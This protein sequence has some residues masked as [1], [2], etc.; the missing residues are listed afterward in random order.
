MSATG[1]PCLRSGRSGPGPA[2]RRRRPRL[3]IMESR[4]LLATFTVWSTD[5]NCGIDPSPGDNTGTLRQAIVDAN[6]TTVADAIVFAIDSG[7]QTIS[8]QA[9]LPAISEPV[10]IDGTTQPGWM[11]GSIVELDGSSAGPG[12]NGLILRGSDS[13]IRGLVINRF[14]GCGIFV[15]GTAAARNLIVGNSIGTDPTGM[16]ARPNGLDGIFLLDSTGNTIGGAACADRNVISGNGRYG[17][18]IAGD[19]SQN[20]VA[21]NYVGMTADGAGPLGN[22][23]FGVRLVG[24]SSPGG[25]HNTIGGT[26]A[27]MRNVISGGIEIRGTDDLIAGNFLGTDATGMHALCCGGIVFDDFGIKRN[28]T[29]GG[30]TEAARNIISGGILFSS[31]AEDSVVQG[32]FIGIDVTG[33][34]AFPNG[35]DAI[36]LRLG[37]NHITIGGNV[38][39]AGNV[40]SGHT[41]LGINIWQGSHDI[42]IAGNKIGTDSIGNKP[43]PNSRDGIWIVAYPPGTGDVFGIRVGTDG[44]GVGDEFERNIIS[45]NGNGITIGG[46]GEGHARGVVVAGNYI[47]LGADGTTPMGNSAAGVTV[48]PGVSD[49]VIGGTTPARRNVISGNGWVAVDIQAGSSG[50][51][52]LGN[53]IGTDATGKTEVTLHGQGF[54]GVRIYTGSHDNTIGGTAAGAGNLIRG[55][56]GPGVLIAGDSTIGNVIRGNAIDDNGVDGVL[57][58]DGAV[59]NIIGGTD[60]GAGNVITNNA[61]NGVTVVGASV[62][63]SIRGNAISNNGGVGIDLGGDGV[64]LNDSLGHS[65]PNRFPD[66]P[67]IASAMNTGSGSSITGTVSGP[68]NSTLHIELFSN[69]TADPSGYGQGRVFLGS[70][71]VPTNANGAGSFTFTTNTAVPVG[72]VVSATAT[73]GSGSTSEF[74]RDSIVQYDIGFSLLGPLYNPFKHAYTETVTLTNKGTSTIPGFRFVLEGL[75]LGVTLANASGTIGDGSPFVAV[76]PLA[77]GQSITLTLTFTKTSS[78]LYINY[79]PLFI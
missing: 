26:V 28:I 57:I 59:N 54:A 52:V 12:A 40:I 61:R 9:A 14:G 1:F 51:M 31:G 53:D 74:A 67:V 36:E 37:A 65:G 27:G 48:N 76:G 64:T 70:V 23:D 56:D 34:S 5:D 71:E 66:F 62:G 33:S 25:D 42:V 55:N 4:T 44:D 30:T 41:G 60:P 35:G 21:G 15:A 39:G 2:W 16:V 78:D 79:T 77:P 11:S 29:I 58:E 19:S 13:T 3:E 72:Q 32:N 75:A 49:L 69:P 22:T 45:G 47:G 10:T 24:G 63:N 7:P 43:L 50:T 8:L 68:A 18:L 17:V 38:A 6:A 73:D 46:S 20:L